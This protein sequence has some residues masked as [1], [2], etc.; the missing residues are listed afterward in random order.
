MKSIIVAIFVGT[1]QCSNA[2]HWDTDSSLLSRDLNPLAGLCGN[3]FKNEC[4][5][6][7][8]LNGGICEKKRSNFT[9]NC[10]GTGFDGPICETKPICV[11]ECKNGGVCTKGA[12]GNNTCDC[13][14]SGY[15]GPT[16]DDIQKCSPKCQM[17]SLCKKTGDSYSCDCSGTG[18]TGP[19]CR[20]SDL[21]N[22]F[23]C[24]DREFYN[25]H[26]LVNGHACLCRSPDCTSEYAEFDYDPACLSFDPNCN[27]CSSAHFVETNGKCRA[28]CMLYN[29]NNTI[30]CTGSEC[31]GQTFCGW[32]TIDI[33]GTARD[34]VYAGGGRMNVYSSLGLSV[35]IKTYKYGMCCNLVSMY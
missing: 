33:N 35:R 19:T 27:G 9:C 14:K 23:A 28:S 21:P 22:D 6:S 25:M 17:G 12:E 16:C 24:G 18:F 20:Y 2:Y 34:S 11:P 7:P 26:H 8:C 30:L 32:V 4:K 15:E 5:P 13:T 10:E 1:L 3:R 29:E 31:D